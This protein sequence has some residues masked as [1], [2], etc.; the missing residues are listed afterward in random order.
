MYPLCRS[1]K[2]ILPKGKFNGLRAHCNIRADPDLGTNYAALHHVACGCESCKEQLGWPWVLPCVDV[3]TQPRYSQNKECTL[4]PSYE[5]GNDSKI[6]QL[7]PT[8][9][10]DEKGVR[11]SHHSVLGAMEAR[12]SLMI[13]EGEVGAISTADKATMGYYVGLV[14]ILAGAVSNVWEFVLV[15]T[16][17]AW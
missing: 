11:E 9:E 4:W 7:V 1:T 10:M 14:F 8:T 5:G 3:A 12:M 17:H 15:Q 13:R 6:C 16:Y 2:V